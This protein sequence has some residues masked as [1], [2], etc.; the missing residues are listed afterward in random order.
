[1]NTMA[2]MIAAMIANNCPPGVSTDTPEVP[3]GMIF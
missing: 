3:K 2:K 1:M